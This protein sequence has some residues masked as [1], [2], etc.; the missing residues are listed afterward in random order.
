[1]T[2][3]FLQCDICRFDLVC[4]EQSIY[5]QVCKKRV[6]KRCLEKHDQGLLCSLLSDPEWCNECGVKRSQ[7]HCAE[8][9]EHEE[10]E[11]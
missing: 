3:P 5:C 11:L 8:C 2:Y 7:G 4:R 1:M 10:P 9:L 6:C